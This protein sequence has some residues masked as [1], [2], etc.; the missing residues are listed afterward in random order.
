LTLMVFDQ[1]WIKSAIGLSRLGLMNR[2]ATDRKLDR[3]EAFCT[4]V[5]DS[6]QSLVIEDTFSEFVFSQSVLTQDYG[7]RSYVGAPLI[8]A[9]GQCIGSLSILDL[10]ARRFTN[11]EIEFLCVTARW[12]MGEFERDYLIKKQA[13]ASFPT[14]SPGPTPPKSDFSRS[15]ADLKLKLLNQLTQELRSP[16]TAVIG[17]SSV[18]KG[19]VFGTLT[20][21]QKDYI[22]IIHHSGENLN[23]LVEEILKI[24][25]IEEYPTELALMPVN[26]EMLIQKCLNSLSAIAKQ[27]RQEIRLSIDP[28]KRV[29]LLDKEK[30]KQAVYYLLI[31]IIE[32]SEPG[33][34]IRIHISH[35]TQTLNISLWMYHPWIGDGL[36]HVHLQPPVMSNPDNISHSQPSIE[37]FKE[38]LETEG[39]NGT[40]WDSNH[41]ALT[42]ASLEEIIHQLTHSSESGQKR[43]HNLLGLL[44]GCY[45]AD[46]HNGKV[47][48]QGTADSGYRY[49]LILPKS[50]DLEA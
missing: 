12:C 19:Q 48:L 30:V 45:L 28:G 47:V 50:S 23:A 24:G 44:L 43:P 37:L 33:G 8:T 21:K 39:I 25:A 5:V 4:Y 20:Q 49:V 40:N 16:L 10:T 29:W 3:L 32:A 35:R 27:K 6:Q 2:L 22:E 7:I 1:V 13:I 17:M 42:V 18:L 11:R 36:P 15:L 14:N 46:S 31:S 26:I 9:A 38:S 41:Q 34:E